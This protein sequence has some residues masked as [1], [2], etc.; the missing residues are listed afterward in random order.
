MGKIKIVHIITKLELGGAQG[1]TLYTVENLDQEKYEVYLLCG[2]GGILDNKAKELNRNKKIKLIFIKNLVRKINPWKDLFAFKELLMVLDKIKPDIVHTHS[3][4]AGILGRLASQTLRIMDKNFYK[5]K[6]VH[7]FHG[8]G[9][10]EYQN[11]IIKNF[12]IK[13][14][15]L[16]GKFTDKLIFVSE[17]NIYVAARKYKIGDETKYKLIRS[18]IKISDFQ[19]VK[20]NKMLRTRVLKDL[21]LSE[22]N[23]IITTI[24]PFKP[25][26]N[27]VDFIKLAKILVDSNELFNETKRQLIFLIAGDG[28]Q[29]KMLEHLVKKYGLEHKIKFLSWYFDIPGLLAIT[30]IFVMTSLWEGLPRS[31]VESLASGVPVVAYN[32]D[33]LNDIIISDYNGYLVNIKDIDKL[34]YYVIELLNNKIKLER[35]KSNTRKVV[36]KNFDIV[37]MVKQQEELYESLNN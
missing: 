24:G 27:L 36:D 14:E 32:A 12:Y 1:N 7:T 20:E 22:E 35:L 8:F 10:N 19:N 6:I 23:K 25:Q 34:A 9:F 15:Q 3:S 30:D 18:G 2:Y 31:A 4:K 33:G 21:K 13:L 17:S 5:T 29:R 16:A 26:K 28:E 11:F 37:Y